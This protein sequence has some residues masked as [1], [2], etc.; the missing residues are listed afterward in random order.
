M[1]ASGP[2]QAV[3]I[4]AGSLEQALLAIARQTGVQIIFSSELVHG[5]VSPGLQGRYTLDSALQAALAGS[6]L[7]ARRVSP[8]VVVIEPHADTV[9]AIVNEPGPVETE[10]ASVMREE[11]IVTASRRPERMQVT[12]IGLSVLTNAGLERRGADAI[13]DFGRLLPGVMLF[14]A[15]RNR[16]VFTIR[17]IATNVFGS[18]SQDPVS[19]YLNETPLVDSFGAVVQP[20][21][22]LFDIDRV[23]VLRGPQGTLFGSGALGGTVRIITNKPDAG[24][25]E[26]LGRV[27]LGRTGGGG[28]RQRYDAMLNLPLVADELALRLVGYYRDEAGW[29]RNITLDT[30]NSTEDWGG[31]AA[32]RW[33]PGERLAANLELIHQDSQPED[34][35]SWDPSLGRF[36]KSSLIPEGRPSTLS[37]YHLAIDY[38]VP[39]VA[40]LLS[41]TSYQE[42]ATAVFTQGSGLP[43]LGVPLLAEHDPWRTRFFTQEFRLLGARQERLDWVAGAAFV[44]RNSMVRF[45]IRL[46]DLASELGQALPTENL[47]SSVIRLQSQ[48]L[49]VFGD[50]GF[51]ASERWRLFG[52]ARLFDTR[53]HYREPRRQLLD[54]E[55]LTLQEFAL[56]ND[57]TD[58]GL[59]WRAGLSFEPDAD[60]ML[61]ASVS[62]GYRIG[63]VNPNQ[64]AEGNSPPGQ[65]I[66]EGYEPDTTLNY[67]V[68]LKSGWFD[69][70][71]LLNLALYHIDW[72]NIQI[73]ASRP[74]DG[75]SFI[76][77]AGRAV[78]RGL[79]LELATEPVP[80]LSADLA[81]TLQDASIRSMDLGDGLRSGARE[82]DTLPG[83]AD[84]KIAG[85]LQY[86]WP[87]GRGSQ[88]YARL[89]A[90]YVGAS[91]AWFS[92][93][94]GTPRNAA[95]SN[96]NLRLGVVARRWQLAFYIEN[97]TDN[98]D[99]ILRNSYAGGSRVNTLRPR[100]V[101]TR[102]KFFY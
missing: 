32:L 34:G 66:P 7:D 47:I 21:L 86:E 39:G 80:G 42:S 94:A 76:T 58:H 28:W 10:V 27:D 63:Q 93:F 81:V 88:L 5:I 33:Q 99:Q 30:N 68:G 82:G 84:F 44:D 52:G 97:L 38:E 51:Q 25:R 1:A 19:V 53:V 56:A 41:A 50:L 43:S 35:D 102:L 69:Q 57:N 78:S 17:G 71:L 65:E 54:L 3:A 72:E 20:D 13:E 67:E 101:G 6:G 96:V 8:Q 64:A 79:E 75:L 77:N 70:R 23:E 61:Y 91:P 2:L 89:D 100:T 22:R 73:D 18:N 45:N 85:S 49:A 24:A 83:S 26:A 11:V 46:P 95:Y 98:D 9:P 40:S 12:P 15:N 55:T 31:R 92:G 14:Q 4:A 48:E 74:S 62:K 29:V 36:R 59:T 87:T 60:I 37:N 16:G 90:Q